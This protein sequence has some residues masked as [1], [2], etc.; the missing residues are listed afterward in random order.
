M[1]N[2]D[3][4]EVGCDN[5]DKKKVCH[6]TEEK[7]PDG[8]ILLDTKEMILGIK[9]KDTNSNGNFVSAHFPEEIHL[10]SLGCLTEY[11]SKTYENLRKQATNGSK[12]VATI[13]DR[14]VVDLGDSILSS[15]RV[16]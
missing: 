10:C 15:Y 16:K 9:P 1:I 7:I 3:V 8:W 5:C 6:I 12:P 2:K 4:Q 13:I 14:C 11:F